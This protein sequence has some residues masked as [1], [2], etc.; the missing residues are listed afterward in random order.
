MGRTDLIGNSPKH[1]IPMESPE[2]RALQAR[3]VPKGNA[4]GGGGPGSVGK[5]PN[6][7]NGARN[8]TN[9]TQRAIPR[10]TAPGKPK[11]AGDC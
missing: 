10:G 11:A 2:E 6:R 3:P 8:S 5:I 9:N 4:R 1:L 7:S